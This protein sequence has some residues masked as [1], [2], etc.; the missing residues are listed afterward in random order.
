MCN[1]WSDPWHVAGKTHQKRVRSLAWAAEERQEALKCQ[2]CSGMPCE[3]A[4][5]RQDPQLA[6]PA[7][8]LEGTPTT[9]DGEGRSRSGAGKVFKFMM[10]INNGTGRGLGVQWDG[11]ETLRINAVMPGGLVE[12][13]NDTHNKCAVKPGDRI[14]E[15]NEIRNDVVQMTSELHRTKVL[16]L[17]VERQVKPQM[18]ITTLTGRTKP[19]RVE[20]TDS[21]ESV[22]AEVERMTG[23]PCDK[24]RL[25]VAGR[26]LEDGRT[27]SDY[28]L[29]SASTLH[30]VLRLH[31]G[32][33]NLESKASGSASRGG[34]ETSA[35]ARIDA[36]TA[37]AAGEPRVPQRLRCSVSAAR[38]AAAQ[39]APKGGR[40]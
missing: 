33:Q 26:Q 7:L 5:D 15:V 39:E 29:Q 23:V 40:G 37:E 9:P 19:L 14:V 21:I 38:G 10:V 24:Q 30:L 28:N 13:W 16:K 18:F 8:A 2:P 12:Q 36:D 4:K 31:G 17:L 35:Q 25:L 1:M 11:S 20:L 3:P 32:M 34:M 6:A 22:R 27:L